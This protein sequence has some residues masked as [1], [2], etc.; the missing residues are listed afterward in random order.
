MQREQPADANAIAPA[1]YGQIAIDPLLERLQGGDVAQ[2]A[3]ERGLRLIGTGE[4]AA[5]VPCKELPCGP[6]DRSAFLVLDSRDDWILIRAL[7][8]G[9]AGRV[10]AHALRSPRVP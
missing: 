9:I 7:P 2:L 3:A 8:F 10:P 1:R 6:S 4:P 5:S